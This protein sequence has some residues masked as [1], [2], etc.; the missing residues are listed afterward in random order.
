MLARVLTAAG[1]AV[2]GAF[3]ALARYGLEGAISRRAPGAFPWGTFVVNITGAYILGVV[4]TVLTERTTVEPWIRSAITI[5]FL[6]AYTTFSTLS[7]EAYRLLVDGAIGLAIANTIGSL[8]VGLLA[9]YLGVVTG[10][11]V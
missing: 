4:F 7:L 11:L 3:G 2:A 10:R 6:G 1:I 9:V 8:S 5:G